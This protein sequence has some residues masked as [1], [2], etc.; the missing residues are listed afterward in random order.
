INVPVFFVLLGLSVWV[1]SLQAQEK[2]APPVSS[3]DQL[4]L[5]VEMIGETEFPSI[6]ARL[7]R[8]MLD[9]LE[10]RRNLAP[11]NGW[12]AISPTLA[13][14][15][16]ADVR[17]FSMELSQLFGDTDAINRALQMIQDQQADID[18]RRTML[19]SLLNQQNSEAS[20]LLESL[21]QEPGLIQDAIRGYAIVE[22]DSASEV[23]LE[24]YKKMTAAQKRAVVETLSSRET[25]ARKLLVAMN[26]KVIARDDIPAHVARSLA[27]LLGEAFTAVYGEVRSVA[28]DRVELIAKYKAI[29]T[30]EAL[31]TADASNGRAIFTKTCAACHSLYG[32][33]GKVGPDLTG[34]NR[35]NLDYILLNSVAPSFD[36]PDAYKTV[37]IITVNGRIVNGVLAEEDD[38]RVILKT[39]EEARLV[40]SKEDIDERNISPKSMMPDGQLDKMKPAEVVDLIKYLRTVKQV[41]LPK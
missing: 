28:E 11:P 38:A 25:Y 3:G 13:T 1:Y 7:L 35:A 24:C 17:R 5:L 10:G 8:G 9:G 41:D 27:E 26:D 19:R 32:I 29:I 36:V 22:N 33:G 15:G 16:N 20:S 40:I 2:N 18:T 31:A 23:L 12:N 6:R 37:R 30:D 21:M 14:S 4:E 39:A 34:S